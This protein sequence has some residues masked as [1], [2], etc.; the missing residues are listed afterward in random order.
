MVRCS[1]I[2]YEGTMQRDP[3]AMVTYASGI[4]PLFILIQTPGIQNVAF[5]DDISGACRISALKSWWEKFFYFGPQLGYYP[6]VSKSWF[7]SKSN[8]AKQATNFAQQ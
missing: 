4:H 3:I 2:I 1:E 8:N 5:A 6:N 7:I